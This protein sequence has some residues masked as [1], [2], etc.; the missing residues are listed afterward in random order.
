MNI[1]Q[2]YWFQ[3]KDINPYL[4]TGGFLS[5]ETHW[6]SW[7]LSCM[8]LKQF[9]PS[10]ELYTDRIGAEVFDSFEIPYTKINI[11]HEE[12]VMN[13]VDPSL[14]SLAKILT[15]SIQT[16]PFLHIDGDVF[17]WRP[18]EKSFLHSNVCAQCLEFNW[19]TYQDC[20]FD[21]NKVANTYRPEWM[22]Y[23]MKEPSGYNAGLLGG[24]NTAFLNKYSSES[25][26]FYFRNKSIW[27][28]LSN[29]NENINTFIEQYSLYCLS[30]QEKENVNTISKDRLLTSKE[31]RIYTTIEDV[32][33][34]RQLTHVLG[35]AKQSMLMNNFISFVLKDKY[36]TVWDKVCYILHKNNV[37]HHYFTQLNKTESDQFN[38]YSNFTLSETVLEIFHRFQIPSK[39][40][41]PEI[42]EI[43]SQTNTF[44]STMTTK[45]SSSYIFPTYSKK[46]QESD[47]ENMY[48]QV[49]E[50]CHYFQTKYN[51]SRLIAGNIKSEADIYPERRYY[52]CYCNVYTGSPDNCWLSPNMFNLLEYL[53]THPIKL[54]ELIKK[55][56]DKSYKDLISLQIKLWYTFGLIFFK[57]N[58]KDICIQSYSNYSITNI[59]QQ[60]LTV[61]NIIRH[62]ITNNYIS[63]SEINLDSFKKKEGQEISLLD[64]INALKNVGVSSF[65]AELSYET[66]SSVPLPVI[67][68]LNF[69]LQFSYVIIKQISNK[70][71]TLFNLD[72]NVDETYP[73]PI[74]QKVWS[75]YCIILK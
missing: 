26:N 13:D 11:T 74:L 66:L 6:M 63:A 36:P 2:T 35:G 8:Q 3:K 21:F 20:L 50:H 75:G 39:K 40:Y 52:T 33:W 16:K 73:L 31:L 45:A 44:Y 14:W 24:N 4:N 29:V 57:K 70:N 69:S 59:K 18:L 60:Q 9:F 58:A 17:L 64:I 55:F 71:V 65:G 32:P 23:G 42:E 27:S 12:G 43:E 61:C 53:K 38:N 46:Y 68:L 15:Y 37:K 67:A 1:I 51:W 30:L 41:M 72:T 62:L 34:E 7:A 56:K 54:K 25:L 28:R 5:P 22:Q 48:I 47:F 49:S 19:D 10:V